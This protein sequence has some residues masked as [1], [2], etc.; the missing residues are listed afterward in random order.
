MPDIKDKNFM[1]LKM[2]HISSIDST[3]NYAARLLS[4][5]QMS[6]NTLI[7]ADYQ[8]QG[9]GHGS[10]RWFSRPRKNLLASLYLIHTDIL[11]VDQ[12]VVNC[13]VSSAIAVFLE[14]E[15]KREVKIKWP[16]DIYVNR[17]KIAGLLIESF[18]TGERLTSS[19]IGIGLNVNERDFPPDIPNPTSMFLQD[20]QLRNPSQVGISITNKILEMHTDK[21][22]YSRARNIYLDRL[23]QKGV[24]A[25]YLLLGK[26]IEAVITGI[27]NFGRLILRKGTYEY[28]CNFKEVVYLHN[29]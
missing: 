9:R 22:Q 24:E 21:N 4:E 15:L 11:A 20:N 14:N 8:E 25:N 2:I 17:Q 1:N 12:F 23:Y 26:K 6:D 10:N 19:I 3:N 16:N 7:I 29:V 27:D 13:I 18:I 5:N 28:H